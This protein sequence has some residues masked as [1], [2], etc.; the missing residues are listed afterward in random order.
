MK[1]GNP[2]RHTS[3]AIRSRSVSGGS[4]RHVAAAEE[5]AQR[6]AA[7][8]ISRLEQ[9][10]RA[11]PQSHHPPSGH[12][13]DCTPNDQAP[14]RPTTT[15]AQAARY[16]T[17]LQPLRGRLSLPPLDAPRPSTL[18]ALRE[19]TPEDERWTPRSSRECVSCLFTLHM[20]C[21]RR[22]AIAVGIVRVEATSCDL[23]RIITPL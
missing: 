9:R 22:V 2:P 14:R 4:A 17:P 1:R 12:T 13:A 18:R 19:P 7:R 10:H 8:R 15:L 20:G 11:H 3:S 21:L 23:Q 5:P 16:R 6:D